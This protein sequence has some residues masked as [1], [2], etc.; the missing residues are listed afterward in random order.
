MTYSKA[1]ELARKKSAG[2]PKKGGGASTFADDLREA[3]AVQTRAVTRITFPSAR[4]RNDPVGFF[5]LVLGVEPWSKQ[6]EVIEAIRDN[7]RVAVKSGHKV[8]KSH[9]AAGTALW[10]YCSFDDARVVMTSTTSRQVDSILW[11]ELRMMRARSGICVDCKR[12]NKERS[13][14]DKILAPCPHSAIIDGEIGELARTGL[15]SEDFREVSGFTAREA[16]AV[17]GISGYNL[18]YI[19]DEASGIKPEIYEAIEGNRAGGARVVMF[20]NPTRT[21]GDFYE[22]FTEKADFYS[23]HTISSEETPN[24]VHNIREDQ[25]DKDPRAIPGLAGPEWIEEKKKE[26][27]EDSPL[28]KVRVKGL[29]AE[30]EDAKIFSVEKIAEAEQRWEDTPAIGRLWIGLDPAG[31]TM[32]GDESVW[33]PRRGFKNLG[34]TAMRGLSPAAHLVH[35]LGMITEL[36]EDELEIPV[37]VL[38][39][40]GETG[41]KVYGIFSAFLAPLDDPPFEL[42]AMR[43][44]DGAH[45]TPV[46]YDRQRDELCANLLTWI[47]DGGAIVEDAKLAKELNALQ[48]V[49]QE[50]TGKVKLI[51][52][53]ELRKILD[54]SPDRYD[55]LSL[56][57]WEP[58]RIDDKTT[59]RKQVNNVDPTPSSVPAMD[60]YDTLD[61]Y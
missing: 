43:S 21:S 40:E 39:V 17:A 59:P 55:A 35:T 34:L 56:S 51:A 13:N 45:R 9:T 12:D 23:L 19:L 44:S 49:E 20:S 1:R 6:I 3:L 47:N 22:A 36:R 29:F 2:R 53:K 58:V 26:W 25:I 28:Y 38:D 11:R 42:V 32:V 18:L 30:L 24:V 31:E 37:V 54:R 7:K 10:F 15:K 60:P 57:V 50:R 48:W 52:K 5:R 8:S 46:V 61:P 27:G 33:A 4:W 14:E 16:E 41:H